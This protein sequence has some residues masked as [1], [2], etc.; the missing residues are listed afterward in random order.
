MQEQTKQRLIGVLVIIG[1]LFIIL[2]FL[3]HN[4]RPSA[5]TKLST[6]IPNSPAT[7]ALAV[8]MPADASTSTASPATAEASTT[9]PVVAETPATQTANVSQPAATTET[10][11]TQTADATQP[12]AA[13]TPVATSATNTNV[14][15]VA[16]SASVPTAPTAA[17]TPV[18][19]SATPAQFNASPSALTTGDAN[20]APSQAVAAQQAAT[21]P[22]NSTPMEQATNQAQAPK[23]AHKKAQ[24]TA[25]I[26]KSA[27]KKHVVAK[28]ENHHAARL[29][30]SGDWAIQMGVFSDKKNATHLM[31]ELHA[32]HFA[33]F[34]RHITHDHKTLIVVYV[35]PEMNSRKAAML[36]KHLRAEFKIDGMVKRV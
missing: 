20:E 11:A 23:I 3:F 35:G 9:Q 25:V 4:A 32:N 10:P 34:S 1:A 7:P 8:T 22:V 18:S 5:E 14:T 17:A 24:K 26:E 6:T 27:V 29:A 30:K 28:H 2:P 15:K 33:A 31:T 16:T 19:A 36:Q 12:A 21:L 13:T